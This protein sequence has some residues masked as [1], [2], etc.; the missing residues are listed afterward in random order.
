MSNEWAIS[1]SKMFPTSFGPR[2]REKILC[3][4]P[5]ETLLKCILLISVYLNLSQYPG[6][7][8]LFLNHTNT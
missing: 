7:P 1:F 6:K 3:E 4:F 2:P 8:V 5:L